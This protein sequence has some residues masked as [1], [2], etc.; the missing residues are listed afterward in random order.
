MEAASDNPDQ[1]LEQI[2][3]HNLSLGETLLKSDCQD[4][5]KIVEYLPKLT[6]LLLELM[7]AL[8]Q[9]LGHTTKILQ[10]T[11]ELLNM[12]CDKG[13]HQISRQEG[14]NL[15][16]WLQKLNKLVLHV[17]KYLGESQN[18]L[19]EMSCRKSGKVQHVP[20]I[21]QKSVC[22]ADKEKVNDMQLLA[23]VR[24][25]FYE[26]S[27]I[28]GGENR[29]Q[30]T[31]DEA[32]ET[33]SG[34]SLNEKISGKEQKFPVLLKN[35][36]R[37]I[38]EKS[39]TLPSKDS[40]IGSQSVLSSAKKISENIDLGNR[41]GN[42]GK[43]VT[44]SRELENSSVR[45]LQT[46]PN[47]EKQTEIKEPQ[48]QV[49]NGNCRLIAEPGR[50]AIDV[51]QKEKSNEIAR[52]NQ[53]SCTQSEDLHKNNSINLSSGKLEE[54]N[55]S[56]WMNKE[57]LVKVNGLSEPE[58]ACCISAPFSIL[59][60]LGIKVVNDLSSL[61][62]DDSE[63]LVSNVISAECCSQIGQPIVSPIT[64]AIPFA[65]CYRG[66]YKD[67]MVKV[68]DMNFQS[69]YLTPVTLEGHQGNHKGT[70][71]EIKTCQLGIFSVVSCLKTETVTI[72][73]KGLSRKLSMD[74]RI[75]FCC[76]PSTFTSRIA[77]YLKVQP[78]EPSVI[79]IL[80]TKN[81]VYHL[82]T[83]TS[84][85]V[86]LQHP[87]S[88]PFNKSITIV[89]PCPPNQEKKREGNE[90]DQER[91][92]SASM[93]RITAV[94]R[95]RVMSASPRKLGEN[96]NESLKLLGYRSKEDEWFVL[97]DIPV[98]NARN[99]LVSFELNEPLDSFIIIRLSSAM[100]NTHLV[101][102]IQN[103]EEA[104]HNII[105]KV[106]LYRKKEDPYKIV[107]L[108]VPSKELNLEL[109][110]L[111]EEGFTSP[112]DPS[113]PFQLR[114]GEQVYFRF[115][116]NI[117]ASDDGM[118]FGKTYKLTFHAQRKS[119]LDLQIKEVDEFGNYSSP[120]YKGTTLFYKVSKE[121]I[122][123]NLEQPLLPEDYQHQTLLCKLDLTLPKK[124]KLITRPQST[125]RISPD[126]S[127]ALWDN[128]LYWLSHELSEDNA[129][130]LALS[131]PLHRSTLPL[132]KLKCPDDLTGQIY[133]LL[134]FWNRNLPRSANKLQLLSR[135]LYK[136]GR[137]DLVED[138]QFKWEN[139]VSVRKTH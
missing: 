78:I 110:G 126:S 27:S 112:P 106:V 69:R 45:P 76:P 56:D 9:Q 99:G 10:D 90:I 114:E 30:M 109:Q 131:L 68:T 70:L 63:E 40:G 11:Y 66:M 33:E 95:F 86:H 98:Q 49:G 93:H 125:K 25:P 117:Y 47:Q 52:S 55:E 17:I 15:A 36:D 48:K 118:A 39:I 13:W 43:N 89:L 111:R 67:I 134:C 138:L 42:H 130:C 64:V 16:D 1:I 129:S 60:N 35:E 51:T 80:K 71:A 122:A 91:A 132:I 31:E 92:M 46:L 73:R 21:P 61:V 136:S 81:D 94:H 18:K 88:Q 137:S 83:S 23:Y 72:P 105:V 75:S 29:T 50:T 135:Y 26:P 85:L 102:F 22:D 2:W 107:V 20:C 97:D 120:H 121:A 79:S 77:M 62:V 38:P 96:L 7:K 44:V 57:F 37:H 119:R 14:S 53:E 124:E 58:V 5:E 104:I 128:L 6:P 87:S 123:K 115:S 32:V 4:N 139:Y 113:Q 103:L 133:E 82:V 74:S 59:E 3:H 28:R 34:V 100:D 101:Q 19:L 8:S 24:Q 127:E 12:L 108:L 65:S 84:P 41:P 54:N 116:G